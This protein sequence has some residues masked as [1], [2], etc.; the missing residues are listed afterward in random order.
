[1][2]QAAIDELHRLVLGYFQPDLTVILDIPVDEGLARARN[3]EQAEGSR[4]DRYERMDDS[5]HQRLRDGFLDIARRNPERC[6]VIDAAQEPETVQTEIR[7]VV[8]QRLKV[9]WA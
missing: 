1:M 6:V 4:E 9:T 7:A 2:V 5:F 3:R 8:G